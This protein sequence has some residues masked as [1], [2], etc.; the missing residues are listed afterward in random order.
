MY[1]V[2]S[3]YITTQAMLCL[4]LPLKF[5]SFAVKACQD[6]PFMGQ[7]R[8]L[9][10]KEYLHSAVHEEVQRGFPKA[11]VFFMAVKTL[12]MQAGIPTCL[13]SS[14]NALPVN[15]IFPGD[16]RTIVHGAAI[17]CTALRFT[18]AAG[19]CQGVMKNVTRQF[20]NARKD[21]Y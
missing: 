13:S 4:T 7:N 12:K 20:Y 1:T 6:S 19:K 8:P 5:S 15:D 9:C 18:M 2:A 17:R 11:G 16:L 3:M 10:C 14:I 21:Y